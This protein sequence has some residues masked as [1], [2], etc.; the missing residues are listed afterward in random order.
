MSAKDLINAL[1]GL[2][3]QNQLN[4][5][6]QSADAKTKP[7]FTTERSKKKLL[8]F[9]E[10]QNMAAALKGNK[11]KWRKN[12]I[13]KLDQETI[14]NSAN[15]AFAVHT[16]RTALI[17]NA[18]KLFNSGKGNT[19]LYEITENPKNK[20]LEVFEKVGQKSAKI[21]TIN[22]NGFKP[23][24][25]GKG[26]WNKATRIAIGQLSEEERTGLS[27]PVQRQLHNIAYRLN[28]NAGIT[29]A[30]KPNLVLKEI[31]TFTKETENIF[32]NINNLNEGLPLNPGSDPS[33][34]SPDF[35]GLYKG[36]TWELTQASPSITGSDLPGR[37]WF[38]TIDGGVVHAMASDPLNKDNII[39]YLAFGGLWHSQ[40]GGTTWEQISDQDLGAHAA[41][42]D[43][44][45][46][47][48]YN[49]P[50]QDRTLMLAFVGEPTG[51]GERNYRANGGINNDGTVN[52]LVSTNSGQT[53][54]RNTEITAETVTDSVQLNGQVI[55]ADSQGIKVFN[56]SNGWQ[57][58]L[59]GNPSTSIALTNISQIK[60][61]PGNNNK[62][63]AR[64]LNSIHLIDL[65]NASVS[66]ISLPILTA[67]QSE[68]SKIDTA[69]LGGNTFRLF[70]FGVPNE[71][72][73]A[74]SSQPGTATVYSIDLEKN[75]SSSTISNVDASGLGTAGS[76]AWTAWG[77]PETN[78]DGTRIFRSSAIEALKYG[79][80]QW[81]HTTELL[82]DPIFPDKAYVG[83]TSIGYILHPSVQTNSPQERSVNIQWDPAGWNEYVRDGFGSQDPG[84]IEDSSAIDTNSTHPE[85]SAFISDVQSAEDKAHADAQMFYSDGDNLYY[86]NDGGLNRINLNP[87]GNTESITLK[88]L[89]INYTWNQFK[90][91]LRSNNFPH[92]IIRGLESLPAL[93]FYQPNWESLDFELIANLYQGGSLNSKGDK[94]ISGAQDNGISIGAGPEISPLKITGSDGGNG[95][96]G[97]SDSKV[98]W[99]NQSTESPRGYTL[100]GEL[101]SYLE[102][103]AATLGLWRQNRAG[104]WSGAL[105]DNLV[106]NLLGTDSFR[107]KIDNDFNETTASIE[108]FF[109]PQDNG[110]Q[111]LFPSEASRQSMRKNLAGQDDPVEEIN[112]KWVN[113]IRKTQEEAVTALSDALSGNQASL[114]NLLTLFMRNEGQ[115][116]LEFTRES[117]NKEHLDIELLLDPDNNKVL[118]IPTSIGDSPHIKFSLDGGASTC[119]ARTCENSGGNIPAHSRG[120]EFYFP[121]EQHPAK[122]ETIGISNGTRI[123]VYHDVFDRLSDEEYS[124]TVD[125]TR[126]L[127]EDLRLG[128]GRLST[129]AFAPWD[130]SGQTLLCGFDTGATLLIKNALTTSDAPEIE[131]IG[132]GA[133]KVNSVAFSSPEE[134][135]YTN[136]NDGFFAI[137]HEGTLLPE[138]I[139]YE[140]GQAVQ[141][142]DFGT[143]TIPGSSLDVVIA[144]ENTIYSASTDGVYKLRINGGNW[145]K[146]GG[147][148]SD[149]LPSTRIANLAY[150]E[151]TGR[152]HAFTYGRGVYY[153][154]TK[155]KLDLFPD[156]DTEIWDLPDV[157]EVEG[158]YVPPPDL[159]Q[160]IQRIGNPRIRNGIEFIINEKGD[161]N[162]GIPSLPSDQP[163]TLSKDDVATQGDWYQQN[164]NQLLKQANL[165]QDLSIFAEA[166]IR[167][168][169]KTVKTLSLPTKLVPFKGDVNFDEQLTTS[170][171]DLSKAIQFINKEF[172]KNYADA[173]IL[174][175]YGFEYDN[176]K[177]KTYS[178]RKVITFSG[179]Y[180]EA[181]AKIAPDNHSFVSDLDKNRQS[182]E[183]FSNSVIDPGT[184][185][186]L[187]PVEPFRATVDALT[188]IPTPSGFGTITGE[189]FSLNKGSTDKK[190]IER[191]QTNQSNQM[192]WHPELA[193][194]FLLKLSDEEK[195]LV[196]SYEL[197][198]QQS[199]SREG[200]TST[201]LSRFK[202]FE[203]DIL[204]K[205]D[206]TSSPRKAFRSLP[207][208]QEL[209]SFFKRNKLGSDAI[210]ASK[211]KQPALQGKEFLDALS[212]SNDFLLDF[213]DLKALKG[214][215][216]KTAT[217]YEAV[218][219]NQVDYSMITSKTQEMLN[220]RKIDLNEAKQSSSFNDC[221]LDLDPSLLL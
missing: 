173:T 101:P 185:Q 181:L 35:E 89:G 78:A 208:N 106:A 215:K 176:K 1:K 216:K 210:P 220:W 162:A 145:E 148:Y 198:I 165:E 14:Q 9:D 115:F 141:D 55:L 44:S 217:F 49:L 131:Q 5:L 172:G 82:A 175:D 138:I 187:S 8:I 85:L 103:N 122:K 179:D 105:Q 99:T 157:Y 64:T 146:I 75:F 164:S 113:Y 88:A 59:S 142:P 31:D 26:L 39:T 140:N 130:Q 58:L 18:Y 219:W 90:S 102:S 86:G 184:S 77:Y 66:P 119:T 12:W 139:R 126:I 72:Y 41:P 201:F 190:P 136:G 27:T 108:A 69:D 159:V 218:D 150:N 213:T 196:G 135:T 123:Y 24:S 160:I 79:K 125:L 128:F 169:S 132:F 110:S 37:R 167:S 144:N 180:A 16:Q 129:F 197:N 166:T 46:L 93:G 84:L 47:A 202:G 52:T 214:D 60:A 121:A 183:I 137:S 182:L 43:F 42:N 13:N 91:D 29:D 204:E 51:G 73:P 120:A 21:G 161:I 153:Y 212:P 74:E 152:L 34:L 7:S 112:F 53:W 195:N 54:L 23:T 32:G 3:W 20:T 209:K 45:H 96:F 203:Q 68:H 71:G 189:I 158:Q 65:E 111:E 109:T 116:K 221:F 174:L 57:N 199:P 33:L 83:G 22:A 30:R 149:N 154:D 156:F 127:Q 97:D 56:T 207:A 81:H 117:G 70:Y 200:T 171:I 11:F 15:T 50:S 100:R 92:T 168:Q 10:D 143:G 98:A 147:N 19:F 40:D 191:L 67:S 177:Q 104:S 192:W 194:S 178:G 155:L 133:G 107:V 76:N 118:A 61:I 206:F 25:K 186:N 17:F 36:R 95:F 48:A 6:E 94:W 87:S 151:A 63:I 2:K 38:K 28:E 163:L 134:N 4:V 114:D 211:S 188:M 62:I 205:I 80:N 170:S 124:S 193:G